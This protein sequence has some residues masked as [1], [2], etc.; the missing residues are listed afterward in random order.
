MIPDP[1]LQQI[2]ETKDP[3]LALAAC[4]EHGYCESWSI[5]DGALI[6]YNLDEPPAWLA[7]VLDARDED[8]NTDIVSVDLLHTPTAEEAARGL[9]GVMR[10]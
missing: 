4:T 3:E 9:A 2:M 8:G 6:I 5:I 10:D 1:R 7:P